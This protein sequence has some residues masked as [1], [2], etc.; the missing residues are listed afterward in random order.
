MKLFLEK[1]DGIRTSIINDKII[2]QINSL[3]LDTIEINWNDCSFNHVEIIVE[4]LKTLNIIEIG[5]KDHL[6]VTYT[7]LDDTSINHSIAYFYENILMSYIINMGR[8][9]QYKGALAD[10]SYQKTNVNFVCHLNKE[11][12]HATWNLASL[13]TRND[14]KDFIISF[15]HHAP[16]TYARME[17]YGVCEDESSL[18]FLG[19]SSI[20][21]GAKTSATHQ[22][23]KIMVFDEK[24][25]AKASPTLCIDENDVEAS[26]AAVVGQINEDHIYYLMSRGIALEEAKK[27][28]TLGYLN[29]ILDFF[30]QEEILNEIKENIERRF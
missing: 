27:L 23:A 4:T 5:K 25:K 21:K 6:E 17:N 2:Y 3:D 9:A 8:N 13:S 22:S 15:Y 11:Y 12:A 10:F 29:P 1:N 26:H 19:T 14:Q 28:I 16:H 30:H 7:L 18:N 20:I 24:C